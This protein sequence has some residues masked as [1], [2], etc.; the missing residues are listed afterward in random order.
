MLNSHRPLDN[1]ALLSQI[2]DFAELIVSISQESDVVSA[3]KHI[4]SKIQTLEKRLSFQS[5]QNRLD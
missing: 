5:I 3:A 2:Q 4:L 1:G